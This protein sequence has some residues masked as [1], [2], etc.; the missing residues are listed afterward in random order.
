M[1]FR[2]AAVCC[3]LIATLTAP[4]TRAD[5]ASRPAGDGPPDPAVVDANVGHHHHRHPHGHPHPTV[6][7]PARF[8]TDRPDPKV[9]PLPAEDGA[10]TFAVFGDRTGG[11]VEGVSVLA[12]A[13][14]DTNLLEPDLV[15]TVG[16]LVRGY[17]E[18]PEWVEQAREY[19]GIMAQLKC[20]WFPVAGNHDVYW[21]DK[22]GSGDARPAGEHERN[23]EVHFGPLWY[24]FE[25]KD[26][27]FV[28]LYSDEGNPETGEKTFHKPEAQRISR[29]QLAWLEQTLAKA[30]SADHV[31]VFLHHPRWRGGNYGDDWDK[32]HKLLVAAGN[33]SAVFAGHIH[34]MTYDGTRDGI[35]YVT[36]ATVGGANSFKVPEVGYLHHFNLV[37]VRKGQ[38]SMAAVPVGEVIDPREITDELRGA[39]VR[40]TDARP[41]FVGGPLAMGSDLAV[42]GAVEAVVE[43]PTPFPIDVTV[44]PD[45]RDARWAFAPDHDHGQV[46]PG[47]RRAFKFGVR[48]GAGVADDESFRLPEFV[49]KTDLLTDAFRYTLPESRTPLP[50]DLAPVRLASPDDRVLAVDG[51]G[52]HVAVPSSDLPLPDGPMTLEAWARADR[53]DERVGLVTKAQGSDYGIFVSKGEPTFSVFLG[54]RYASVKSEQR[55]EPGRWHHLAGV[56]DGAEV[57]LYVDGRLADRRRAAGRRKT[58]ALPLLVGADVAGG[59]KPDSPFA[60]QIDDVRLSKVAR[61]AGDRFDPDPRPTGDADT[62]LLLNFD[63]M[64][65]GWLFDDSPARRMLRPH[66]GARV[67]DPTTPPG[68]QSNPAEPAA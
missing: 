2:A 3:V 25:H 61:Y 56:Y 58:N 17:N 14:R 67:V 46:A 18:D 19:K 51:A 53:F 34:Y 65:G 31:F 27:W 5:P 62:V 52:A 1:S 30:K 10:F 50:L 12:D 7:D 45:A 32:V 47:G 41:A 59:G 16:D 24:A 38:I 66:G 36:L 49:V 23:F 42:D 6:H 43:N 68:D 44:T 37:T 29:A 33:V 20:P 4:V 35:E 40:L 64:I 63:D 54:D 21:R 26:S 57:R 60:G 55:L 28:A 48:R 15:M 9:L 8:H 22:D 13:V 39:A 11:P